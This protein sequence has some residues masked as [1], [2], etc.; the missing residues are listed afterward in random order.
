MELLPTVAY[1]VRFLGGMNLGLSLL[2]VLRLYSAVSWYRRRDKSGRV[3]GA[4]AVTAWAHA[5][6]EWQVLLALAVAHGTQFFFNLPPFARPEVLT[7]SPSMSF[8]FV[9]DFA[10]SVLSFVAAVLSATCA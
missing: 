5:T 4:A 7:W 2:C 6:R 8:I 10:M 3:V 9:T 1:A